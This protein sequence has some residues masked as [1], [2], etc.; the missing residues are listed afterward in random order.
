[1]TAV[2]RFLYRVL[3][4]LSAGAFNIAHG[5]QWLSLKAYDKSNYASHRA[6]RP[7][8]K[9]YLKNWV[10]YSYDFLV[11]KFQELKVRFTK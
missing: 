10:G 1:M 9:N 3:R 2:N 4:R 5:L 6:S 11:A 8:R 7:K